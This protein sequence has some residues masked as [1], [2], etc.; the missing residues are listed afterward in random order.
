MRA[1]CN[2]WADLGGRSACF[3]DREVLPLT[4]AEKDIAGLGGSPSLV[5]YSG[6]FCTVRRADGASLTLRFR[7]ESGASLATL[8]LAAWPVP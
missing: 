3:L 8:G 2:G 1:P 6:N 7:T 5:S 4:R